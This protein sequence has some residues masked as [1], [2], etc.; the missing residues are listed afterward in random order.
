MY[1]PV[2]SAFAA[3][4]TLVL[5]VHTTR[6]VAFVKEQW[7]TRNFG[8]REEEEAVNTQSLLHPA[9]SSSRSYSQR[10]SLAEGAWLTSLVVPRS[11]VACWERMDT[12]P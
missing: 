9:P 6:P 11:L 10:E 5:V 8:K 4:R 7:E 1:H 3:L 2:V 12:P